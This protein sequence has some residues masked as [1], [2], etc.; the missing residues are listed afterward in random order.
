MRKEF[1]NEFSWSFSRDNLF[2][3]CKRKYYYNYY[4]SWEGW[5]KDSIDEVTRTLYVLKNLVNR[6]IWKGDAV[7]KEISRV[8]KSF[9]TTG[10]ISSFETSVKRTTQIMREEFK[11]SKEKKYWSTDKSLRKV[12]ALFE[13]EYEMGVSDQE[14]IDNYNEVIK[15]LKNFHNSEIADE[16][17]NIGTD[18]I[19]T[20][21][22][23]TPT[24]F[25]FNG[26]IIYVNLDLAY[27]VDD[28]VKI[29]DWKT[30]SAESNPLQF[31]VYVFHTNE[32]LGTP[33]NKLTVIEYNLQDNKQYI[34]KFNEKEILETKEYI[35]SSMSKMKSYLYDPLN[36]SAE[37]SEF[38]RTEDDWKCAYCNFKKICFDLP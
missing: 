7:H 19:I 29:V 6:K 25:D 1:K 21:D 2:N 5:K 18:S 8:L 10:M 24:P 35:D 31:V 4:G 3:E 13:H 11:F 17:K 26:E 20:I 12:N 27:R 28:E 34:H 36:N 33:L 14:W 23:I 38:P 15:C 30:G 9:E 22:S 37:I 32:T 16:L